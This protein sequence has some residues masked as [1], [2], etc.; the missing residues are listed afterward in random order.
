MQTRARV[1]ADLLQ[2]QVVLDLLLAIVV[3]KALRSSAQHVPVANDRYRQWGNRY[4]QLSLLQ[5]KNTSSKGTNKSKWLV[6][7]TVSSMPLFRV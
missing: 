1:K 6:V 2:T 4:K 7:G 5:F 3:A